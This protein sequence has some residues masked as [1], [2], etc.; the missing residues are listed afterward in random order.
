MIRYSVL[1]V[2]W[3]TLSVVWIGSLLPSIFIIFLGIY[4]LNV[5]IATIK[6][7]GAI[8]WLILLLGSGVIIYLNN[9]IW[10]LTQIFYLYSGEILLVFLVGKYFGNQIQKAK[11]I[12]FQNLRSNQ[13]L[14]ESVMVYDPETGLMLKQFAEKAL[15]VEVARSHRLNIPLSLMMISIPHEKAFPDGQIYN[16]QVLFVDLLRGNL[17][18]NIDIIFIDGVYGVI[19]PEMDR[20]R[21]QI[22]AG[23]LVEDMQNVLG[24]ET[25][26]G[27]ASLTANIAAA[28]ALMA[29]AK[30]AL[31]TAIEIE[32]PIITH[33]FLNN[34]S[35]K[36]MNFSDLLEGIQEKALMRYLRNPHL[37]DHEWIIWLE[38]VLD[39][40]QFM[41][42]K[43]RVKSN[44]SVTVLGIWDQFLIVKL[45]IRE[46]E[47]DEFAEAF[48]G[49]QI[50]DVDVEKRFAWVVSE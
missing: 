17:R 24:I 1:L 3:S 49:W 13:E 9:Q 18:E 16:P 19:M 31:A 29:A 40:A 50:C 36:A 28:D 6:V 32:Q 45:A 39:K 43:E 10:G 26:I 34:V 22:A 33:H 21:A 27:I 42:V 38:G 8:S 46:P 20:K 35:R 15:I 44:D 25:V 14:M 37:G 7:S 41:W 5:V 47:A 30:S 48:S 11:Q 2:V 12:L 4:L 23:Q